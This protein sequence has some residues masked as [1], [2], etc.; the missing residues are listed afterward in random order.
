MACP[1]GM[2]EISSAH[3][4]VRLLSCPGPRSQAGQRAAWAK[5]SECEE[6][7]PAELLSHHVEESSEESCPMETDFAWSK[8]QS[9]L[10]SF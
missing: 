8:N 2:A 7:L 5:G 4:S 6:S 3:P 10:L 9:L 1:A